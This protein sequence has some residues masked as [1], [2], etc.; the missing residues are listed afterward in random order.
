MDKD[1]ITK[2]GGLK[3][4]FFVRLYETTKRLSKEKY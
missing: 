2:S 4:T 1:T 3:Y